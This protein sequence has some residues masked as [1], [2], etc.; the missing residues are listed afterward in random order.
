[1]FTDIGPAWEISGILRGILTFLSNY[2]GPN[3]PF[4]GYSSSDLTKDITTGQKQ[5]LVERREEV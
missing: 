2:L 5:T 3:D 1:M 4:H